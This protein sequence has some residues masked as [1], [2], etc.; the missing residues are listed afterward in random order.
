MLLAIAG[1][2]GLLAGPALRAFRALGLSCVA[3][4]A[5]LVLLQGKPYYVGPVYPVLFAAGAVPLERSG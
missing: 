1:L 5:I 3:A 2:H 4:F